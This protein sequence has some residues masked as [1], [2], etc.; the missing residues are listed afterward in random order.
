MKLIKTHNQYPITMLIFCHTNERFS[1]KKLVLPTS[2]QC[3]K[4]CSGNTT[5]MSVVNLSRDLILLEKA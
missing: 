4:F 1:E 2:G 5:C 3:L